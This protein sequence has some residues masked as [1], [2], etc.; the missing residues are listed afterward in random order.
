MAHVKVV[1][2]S[3][4][5]PE[6]IALRAE[7]LS[8]R[9][10]AQALPN[11][12]WEVREGRQID[13]CR[14]EYY[15]SDYRPLQAGDSLFTPDGTAFLRLS[16]TMP[17]ELDG[18][19]VFLSLETAAEMIVKVNG[20][21]TGALD[22]NRRT[23]LLREKAVAGEKLVIEIEAYNRSKPDDE[24][25]VKTRHLLGC[26]QTFNGSAF[27]VIDH[28]VQEACY[29]V[30]ILQDAMASEYVREEIREYITTHLDKALTLVDYE[31]QDVLKH[32]AA[33]VALRSYLR[34]T[35]FSS[36]ANKGFGGS[37]KVALVA[38]SHLDI[39]YYWR[40]IHTIQK[41]ARTCLVQLRLMDRFP[42]FKYTHT[43]PYTYEQLEK[44]FPEIFAELCQ[45][46]KE[47]RFEPVG[48]MYVE[49]DCNVPSAESLVRQC[50]YGQRYYRSRFGITVNN[51]WL[52]DV[53]GNSWVL[54]QILRKAGVEYFVSNKMS[55]W[56]D[57]NRFPHNHFLWRGID[58]TEI[59]ACVPPTHFITW[60]TPDQV[61]ENWEAFQ[62]KETSPETLNMFGYGDGG[63]GATEEMLAFM[64][65]LNDVP[66]LPEVRHVRGDEFLRDNL[67]DTSE[68]D[69]WDG[70]LY[71]EMHRGTFTTKGDLKKNNRELE[72]A[73]RDAELLATFAMLGGATYPAEE[74]VDAWKL[75][76]VNQFH[77]ILPGTHIA[78]V[79]VDAMDDYRKVRAT[80]QRLTAVASAALGLGQGDATQGTLLNTLNWKRQGVQFVP[81]ADS[82][83]APASLPCQADTYLGKPGVW[84]EIDSVPGC[85]S[86]VYPLAA[87]ASESD[88]EWF[89]FAD[90][91]L[92][93]PL[94]RAEFA[95]NGCLTSLLDKQ[96][97]REVAAPGQALNRLT[98]YRDNPGMYDAWDILPNYKDRTDEYAVTQ[99]LQLLES[100]ALFVTF[101]IVYRIG[102]S[103][104]E[105]RIRFFRHDPQVL[106]EHHVDWHERNRLVKAEFGVDVLARTASCDTGAGI[107]QRDTHRNTTWQQAR[108]ETCH[109]KWADLSES[110]YGVSL[111]NESKYGISF[112]KNT[113]GLSLLR[114]TVRPD[115]Y[116]DEGEHRFAYALVPHTG[117]GP[118]EAGIV[119][120]AWAFN[121]PLH[122]YRGALALDSLISVDNSNLIIQSVKRAEDDDT[123]IVRLTEQT[124]SRGN[125]TVKLNRPV[126]SATMTDLLEDPAEDQ[127]QTLADG[128]LSFPYKPF[129]IITFRCR[130][131]AGAGPEAG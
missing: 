58:G 128:A 103:T 48:A 55:T 11:V 32:R 45:R 53:F 117:N 131:A 16:T 62:E 39:A 41:N 22:P 64:E 75:M 97:G 92:E 127:P 37:G 4:R 110:G 44:Y 61:V 67:Q 7:W 86:V 126:L 69:V 50:L 88:T 15:D 108:F 33:V 100:G 52:P 29:D 114:G 113:F 70:E 6:W 38:H 42:D 95:E 125:A 71:L 98:V 99:P 123:I 23:M 30:D 57:T 13:E 31:E 34:K 1:R 56:N 79:T 109:H 51:C 46:V 21:W 28:D 119:Q 102:E 112:E 80:A 40:R 63:S 54:P 59:P 120:R 17:A 36:K 27:V 35:V 104:W 8:R 85:G 10:F 115:V 49:P 96:A 77:D 78:P 82:A 116:A 5:A 90:G 89:S 73:L 9:V 83:Q 68:L 19:E 107:I 43:Q 87:L 12:G 105:Q 130:V 60:N 129:E 121:T 106:F 91:A 25:S 20:H 74:L 24:R 94:Y 3:M 81:G 101:G 2:R 84:M 26:R 66:G 47:G 65:R 111:L 18:K 76:L 118:V 122:F 93:T 72:T 124:G 14:Y